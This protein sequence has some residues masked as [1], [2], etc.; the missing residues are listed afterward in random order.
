MNS[1]KELG[2]VNTKE[3][4]KKAFEGKFAIP[5][6]NFNNMEQLQAIIGACVET[7]SPVI[8]QVSKGARNYANATLPH[9]MILSGQW[10][11]RPEMFKCGISALEWLCGVQTLQG[12]FAPVGSNGFYTKGGDVAR[13]DQQPVE[14]AATIRACFEA[15]RS[16]QEERWSEEARRVF[17]WFLGANILNQPIYDPATGGCRDGLHPD[18]VNQN[19]GAEST[20]SWL[21]SLLETRNAGS[22]RKEIAE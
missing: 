14:A 4:F 3:M 11:Q 8:L 7:K 16:T 10:M 13:F 21:V 2:L 5:A 18:R 22:V 1:C 20:L 15:Y 12:Y 19:E 9:A 17:D 6:Y